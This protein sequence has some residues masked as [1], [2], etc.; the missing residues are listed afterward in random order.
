MTRAN[1]QPGKTMSY[2]ERMAALGVSRGR[3][4]VVDGFAD[5]PAASDKAKKLAVF[6]GK[7]PKPPVV[8][9][10]LSHLKGERGMVYKRRQRGNEKA[11]LPPTVAREPRSGTEGAIGG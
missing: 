5:E 10:D 9:V 3:L 2:E 6:H 1:N 7:T 11:D 8:V 4:G